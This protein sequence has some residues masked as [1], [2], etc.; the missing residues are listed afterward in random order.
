MRLSIR[1]FMVLAFLLL[2][3]RSQASA[4]YEIKCLNIKRGSHYREMIVGVNPGGDDFRLRITFL[5]G[6]R[7][8]MISDPI[9]A[10]ANRGLWGQGWPLLWEYTTFQSR[11][12]ELSRLELPTMVSVKANDE[13]QGTYVCLHDFN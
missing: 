11:V 1:I 10:P 2:S 5:S 4:L 6:N 8:D 12:L 13:T 9:W 3:F 7:N